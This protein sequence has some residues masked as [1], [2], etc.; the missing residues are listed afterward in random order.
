MVAYCWRDGRFWLPAVAGAQRVRNVGSEP[1]AALLIAEGEDNDHVAVS[2][3]GHAAVHAGEDT[4]RI[5][6]EWMRE[7][8]H[9]RYG[10][11]LE[12]ARTI[13][14]L[15]PIR[16]LSHDARRMGRA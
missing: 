13:V 8:W 9:V 2:V 10:S 6:D 16:V 7:A 1:S 11:E 5:L 15:V 4:R 12:W 14:E 3:E